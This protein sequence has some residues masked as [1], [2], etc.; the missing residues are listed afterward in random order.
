MLYSAERFDSD[1]QQYY[2]RARYYNPTVGRFGAQDQVDG[3]PNDPLSLHKYAYCQNNPV[4]GRDPS[5]NET[6]VSLT[7]SMAI[8]VS[9]Q[10]LNNAPALYIGGK[11]M[12]EGARAGESLEQI[13]GQDA[14]PG[15]DTAT[16]IVHGVNGMW[17]GQPT[18]WSKDFQ[19]DL[20]APN[21]TSSRQV[22]GQKV[23]GS[24]LN[25]DF[26]EFDWAGF[27]F[28]GVGLIPIRSVHQMAFIHLQMAQMLVWMKGYDKMNI[29]SHSWG[30]TLSYDLMN[31]GGIEMHDWVT[32]GSPLKT[33]TD[34]PVWNTGNWI[35]CYSV[36]DW[37]THFEI[38]PPFPSIG[39]SAVGSARG[40]YRGSQGIFGDGLTVDQAVDLQR[41]YSMGHNIWG[42]AEHTAYWSWLPCVNDLRRDLQ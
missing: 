18:G 40:I 16:I 14:T 22:P 11:L 20:Q 33:S 37:V 35:N 26:Y 6:L 1:L 27:S 4:N 15:V 21:G 24:G 29:I 34:K 23:A 2:L 12:T 17:N 41:P 36:K 42:L 3:T 30:T 38:Y 5:G 25:Q 28:S 19:A 31:S 9:I 8:G 7:M 13:E 39:E 32:M 10:L